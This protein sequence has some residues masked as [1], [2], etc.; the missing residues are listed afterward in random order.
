MSCQKRYKAVMLISRVQDLA[1][2]KA[3]TG[4]LPFCARYDP[5][6]F[7]DHFLHKVMGWLLSQMQKPAEKQFGSC[8][9][10]QPV[11]CD[12]TSGLKV[13]EAIGPIALSVTSEIKDFIPEIMIQ[14]KES[15]V[16]RGFVS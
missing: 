5:I 10:P 3:V 2:R 14:I 12:L 11:H 7:R 15:L 8:T 13:L 4:L 6:K 1:V 16:Q 9:F